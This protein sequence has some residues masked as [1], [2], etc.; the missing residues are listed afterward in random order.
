MNK[1]V[2]STDIGASSGKCGLYEFSGDKIILS[3][4]IDFDNI[5]LQLGSSLYWDFF[6]L[7][8]SVI[9]IYGRFSVN[10]HISA[11]GIDTW[12]ATFGFLNKKGNLAEP[13]YHYLDERTLTALEDMEHICTQKE[14]F[15]LTGCQPARSYSL[16]QFFSLSNTQ[17]EILSHAEKVLF[18][19]D[20]FNYFLTGDTSSELTFAGTTALL[21]IRKNEWNKELLKSFSIP[22]SLFTPL[23]DA[24]TIKEKITNS[25]VRQ[26]G[27]DSA[28]K[29]IAVCSH[30]TASAVAGIP[31]FDSQSIYISIGTNINMGIECSDPIITNEVF[32]GGFKNTGGFAR[33]N[34]LYKDFAAFWFINKLREAWLTEGKTYTFDQIEELSKTAQGKG[35]FDLNDIN[36]INGSGDIRVKINAFLLQT[37]QNTLNTDADFVCCIYES[38]VLKIMDTVKVYNASFNNKFKKIFIIN[39]GARNSH[40]SQSIC[41]SI[42]LPV[43]AGNFSASLLGNALVQL[44]SLG[45]LS[46][47]GQM[48][49]LSSFSCEMKEFMPHKTTYWNE[50]FENNLMCGF[51]RKL[52]T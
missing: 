5:S 17:D 21:D 43:F 27:L 12:G 49:E 10:T 41:D 52:N 30:D 34:L 51:L 38:I 15:E 45:E 11:I 26:T 40:L 3:N 14:I 32:E 19:P 47:L 23:V 44:Y 42:G 13:I 8:K 33:T 31:N 16:S 2:I 18:L 48:R 28:T 7:Y 9:N 22:Y 29:V 20:L 36:I 46:S 24:G 50:A 35:F 6:A 39:G 25:A 1:F 37:G 4:K